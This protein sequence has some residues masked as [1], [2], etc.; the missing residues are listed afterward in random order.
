MPKTTAKSHKTQIDAEL[1]KWKCR[2]RVMKTSSYIFFAKIRA[3]LHGLEGMLSREELDS[4]SHDIGNF[5]L[6]LFDIVT[7]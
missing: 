7:R 5:P 2:S 1:R 4:V 6:N 3:N